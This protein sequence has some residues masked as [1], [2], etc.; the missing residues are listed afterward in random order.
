M[1]RLK[2]KNLVLKSSVPSNRLRTV[3]TMPSNVQVVSSS[4][5]AILLEN[6]GQ[7][8]DHI[9]R[10]CAVQLNRVLTKLRRSSKMTRQTQNN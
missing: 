9:M 10:V 1:K 7:D 6:I 4:Q 8:F 3:K 5:M 2:C